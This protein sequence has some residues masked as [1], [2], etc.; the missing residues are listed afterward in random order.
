MTILPALVAGIFGCGPGSA[1]PRG[2]TVCGAEVGGLTRGAAVEAVRE[3]IARDL[4]AHCLTVYAEGGQYSFRFPQLAFADNVREVVQGIRR[5][6]GYDVEISY[7]INGLDE[8]I[9]GIYAAQ[10]RQMLEPQAYF[11]GGDGEPFIYEEGQEGIQPDADKLRED[12]L[13]SLSSRR[14]G[15]DFAPVHLSVCRTPCT[16]GMDEVR[17]RTARLAAYTTY[18]DCENSPRVSNIALAGGK[19]SGCVLMPGQQFSFNGRVGARTAENGFREAKIIEDGRF[20]YGVGGG[21][22]Q[23]STTL[24][25]AALLA[26]LKVTEYHPHSLAVSYVSPSR[27][28]MVSGD[29]SDL[30]FLNASDCPVYIRVLTGL[31]YVRCEIYGRSSGMEYSLESEYVTAE[32]GS[33]ESRCYIT[34]SG[35]G[36]STR[37]LLRKDRYRPAKRDGAEKPENTG[38]EGGVA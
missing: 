24:Y 37:R 17:A 12:M 28:A 32:D 34:E 25:N 4:K 29:Y 23:V 14:Y 33:I 20:V 22:C 38:E 36:R 18:F 5:A 8:V 3:E 10:F 16:M 30:K 2:T 6:G 19:I 7:R 13:S 9:S 21:V 26:G 1:L 27:D 35:G 31:Y 15:E 11:C